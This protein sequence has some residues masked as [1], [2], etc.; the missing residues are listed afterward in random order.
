MRGTKFCNLLINEDNCGKAETGEIYAV[1]YSVKGNGFLYNEEITEKYFALADKSVNISD[2]KQIHTFDMLKAVVEDMTK[3][4]E[5]LGIQGVFPT[6][7]FAP[8]E[9][10]QWKTHIMTLPVFYECRDKNI[11]HAE[12]FDFTYNKNLKAVYDLII[13]NNCSTPD[14]F[15]ITASSDSMT[16][17]S[18]GKSVM[19]FSFNWLWK[20]ISKK[21][22]NVIKRESLKMIPIPFGTNDEEQQGISADN[23]WMH[24]INRNASEAHQQQAIQF[25]SWM[26]TSQ[27]CKRCL[28]KLDYVAPYKSISPD[29]A[30]QGAQE[31]E[32]LGYINNTDMFSMGSKY[33]D[34][35][36]GEFRQIYTKSLLDYANGQKEWDGIVTEFLG[37]WIEY[38]KQGSKI[39]VKI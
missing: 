8:N 38:A 2:M 29:E 17:F 10:H 4:K 7:A 15:G 19:A 11:S 24:A 20:F 23:I 30:P 13:S 27:T 33:I 16:E 37:G 21:P 35:P 14:K 9:D 12:S 36:N 34:I 6:M 26:V 18:S 1:P 22:G 3:H 5:K 25:L 28:A 31:K 39:F 32:L